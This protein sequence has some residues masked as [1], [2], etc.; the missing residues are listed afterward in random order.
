MGKEIRPQRTDVNQMPCL[1]DHQLQC[2]AGCQ[3]FDLEAR[4]NILAAVNEELPPWTDV[5]SFKVRGQLE[6]ASRDQ[7]EAE[8]IYQERAQEL[9][10]QYCSI[11]FAM[12]LLSTLRT[13]R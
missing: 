9:R 8:R 11:A 10:A 6:D 4:R 13:L 5:F 12:G 3:A 2:M 1:H 7:A